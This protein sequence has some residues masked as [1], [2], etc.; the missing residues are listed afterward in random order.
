MPT[1]TLRTAALSPEPA[2]GAP[3]SPPGPSGSSG[4][5]APSAD[6]GAALDGSLVR[7]C[8]AGERKAFDLLVARHT[9]FAGAVAYAVTR[10]YHSALDVVQEAFVKVL[11][12]IETLEE[13][14]RF[15]PWLRNVVRSAALDSLRRQKVVGRSGEALPGQADE[16]SP[17]GGL[18]APNL[19]PAELTEQAELRAQVREVVGTLPESQRELITLKY[20]EGASYE[21]ITRATG[22]SLSSVESRL[23]RARNALR[24]LLVERFGAKPFVDGHS[25]EEG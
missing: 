13:P 19:G 18:P 16:D 25:G 20:L 23:F 17:S 24:K 2:S 11:R 1:L 6:P 12:R 7:R 8:Q 3:A 9:R 21:D 14:E 10:D 22:L 5:A 4:P 15:R